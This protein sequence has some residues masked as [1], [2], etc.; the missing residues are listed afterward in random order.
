[1]VGGTSNKIMWFKSGKSKPLLATS[2]LIKIA[3]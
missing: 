2:V 3:L 1:M